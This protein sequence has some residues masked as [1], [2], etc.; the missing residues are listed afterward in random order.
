MGWG[1]YIMTSGIVRRLKNQNP[2]LQI[3]IKEPFNNTRQGRDIFYKNP[4]LTSIDNFN[5]NK[6]YLKIPRILAGKT[7][8]Q[9]HR[10]I[11]KKERV[12]EIGNL[13]PKSAEISFADKTITII[14]DDWVSKHRKQPKGII[15]ISD[16]PKK[17]VK[18]NN[19]NI[20]YEHSVNREW[21]TDKWIEFS[22]ICREDYILIKT[23]VE[24]KNDIDGTYNIVCD[25]RTSYSIMTKCD[26][27]VG[28]EGGLAH[29]WAITEKKGIVFFGHWISPLVTGYSFHINLT[30]SGND[31]CGSLKKCENCINYFKNLEPSYIKF[32]LEKNI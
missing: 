19:K 23:S 24:N 15:F 8:E 11:W 16:I 4:Y 9:N 28:N 18:L 27:F 22:N 21:G 30:I 29:L 25:F 13:Y 5:E 31:H 32:L 2:N 7:D 20:I 12:A 17:N 10:I 1:D 14:V 26:F 3:L 6:P